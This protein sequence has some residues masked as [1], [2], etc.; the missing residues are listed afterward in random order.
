[1]SFSLI[2]TNSLF[3][4]LSAI[5]LLPL[6]RNPNILT[7][8]KGPPILATVSLI[9]LK[10]VIPYEFPFTSTLASKNVLPTIKVVEKLSVFG[11]VTIGKLLIY[12]WILVS[13]LLLIYTLLGHKKLMEILRLVPKTDNIETKQM[14]SEICYQNQIKNMPKVIQLDINTGPFIA[15]FY[16]PII[17]LPTGLTN[18]EIKFILLHELQHLKYKHLFIKSFIEIV[19]IVYWWNPIIWILRKELNSALEM[20]ADTNVIKGLQEKF[21]PTYLESLIRVS[22][23]TGR[24]KTPDLSLSFSLK[25]SMIEQRIGTALKFEC[26]RKKKK[27]S[28][29][30]IWPLIL[31]SFL[32]LFSFIYTFEAYTIS[33]Q[34]AE[35]TFS[36]NIK[37]DYFIS[38]ENGDYDLYINGEFVLTIP[39]IPEDLSV[40][41]VYK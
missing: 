27:V 16:K 7:Y 15:G 25:N 30:Y 35:N 14:L 29:L 34:N 9:F 28:A 26:Y 22:K 18:I 20:Q 21:R 5:L 8:K 4:L 31:S 41:P 23:K 6:M 38:H 24:N 10:L 32:L 40:L 39:N 19:T 36:I 11:D 33:P 1:M 3:C 13:V 17:V 2:L 37:T 12:I